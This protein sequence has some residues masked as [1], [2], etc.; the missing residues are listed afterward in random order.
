METL[1]LDENQNTVNMKVVKA[2]I[3]RGDK[4]NT[5]SDFT[6]IT[7]QELLKFYKTYYP[8]QYNE[9]IYTVMRNENIPVFSEA[10]EYLEDMAKKVD[11]IKG[12]SR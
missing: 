7:M 12:K 6:G 9:E 11:E 4:F 1:D 3:D 5:I 8:Q 2:M 10:C